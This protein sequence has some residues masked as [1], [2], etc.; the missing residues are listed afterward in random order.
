MFGF[1]FMGAKRQ[2]GGW[3]GASTQPDKLAEEV[4]TDA[5][6]QF[7]ALNN[8]DGVHGQAH[9]FVYEE[10]APGWRRDGGGGGGGGWAHQQGAKEGE[11]EEKS[12]GV[13]GAA[14]VVVVERACFVVVE[15][16]IVDGSELARGMGDRGRGRGESKED[17]AARVVCFVRVRL[18]ARVEE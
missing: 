18:V 5:A 8:P 10:R 1:V 12:V 7:H 15:V 11:E 13:S 4:K 6:G 14:A 9:L 3:F 16:H 2:K 17:G